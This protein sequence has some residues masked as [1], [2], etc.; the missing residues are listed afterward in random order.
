VIDSLRIGQNILA[1]DKDENIAGEIK[2]Q[3]RRNPEQGR[4]FEVNDGGF[5][6]YLVEETQG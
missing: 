6:E 3:P 4:T 5:L 1:E 2:N